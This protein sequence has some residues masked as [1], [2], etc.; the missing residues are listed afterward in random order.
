MDAKKVVGTLVSGV[1]AVLVVATAP[2]EALA[3][4]EVGLV[5]SLYV[6]RRRRMN[7]RAMR[8]SG[9]QRGLAL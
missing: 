2:A 4:I 3:W 6:V 9:S 5:G 1:L 8:Y 7:G